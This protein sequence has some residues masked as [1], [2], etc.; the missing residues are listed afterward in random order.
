MTATAA[1]DEGRGRGEEEG[2]GSERRS[3][4]H[5]VSQS[6]NRHTHAHTHTLASLYCTPLESLSPC[7]LR[8]HEGSSEQRRQLLRL[9]W[10]ESRTHG[11]R[12]TRR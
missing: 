9:V 6:G 4:S 7:G 12:F 11:H 8:P 2:G 1:A 5:P 10:P 3:D